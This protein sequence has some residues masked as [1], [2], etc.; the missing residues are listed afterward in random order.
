MATV[1]KIEI[2]SDWIDY[3]EETLKKKIID[4]LDPDN[5]NFRITDVKRM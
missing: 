1:Y 2:V 5:Q 3:D 4:S